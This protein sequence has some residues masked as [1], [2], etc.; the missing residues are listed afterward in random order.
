MKCKRILSALGKINFQLSFSYR[1]SVKFLQRT[2]SYETLKIQLYTLFELILIVLM[3]DGF[4]IRRKKN[5]EMKMCSNSTAE[6]GSI[7][8]GNIE[9][10]V[11]SADFF[12]LHYKRK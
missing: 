5:N 9:K 4:I 2:L 7:N 1:L 3:K 10:N 8:S 11:D 12:E 6:S